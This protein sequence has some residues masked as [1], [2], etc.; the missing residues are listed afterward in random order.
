MKS[1]SDEANALVSS[2]GKMAGMDKADIGNVIKS[3]VV[4]R[5]KKILQ[6]AEEIYTGLE[7][8]FK[9]IPIQKIWCTAIPTIGINTYFPIQIVI[10]LK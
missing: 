5:A 2:A 9:F 7:G 4:E 1:V 10:R 8:R 6:P 3:G